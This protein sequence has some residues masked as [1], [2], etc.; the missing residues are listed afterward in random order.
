[1]S[2]T[3]PRSGRKRA[4]TPAKRQRLLDAL[5]GG[6]SLTQ[7]ARFLFVNRSSIHRELG[8]DDELRAAVDAARV[9]GAHNH[10]EAQAMSITQV[11]DPEARVAQLE[12]DRAR[13]A[14][15]ASVGQA[16]A[17]SKL[18]AV[19]AAL[20]EARAA[21][22]R[23]RLVE[24]ERERREQERIEREHQRERTEAQ[25]K[26]AKQTTDLRNAY[27]DIEALAA[28]MVVAIKRAV[29]IGAER[30]M[31]IGLLRHLDGDEGSYG[32]GKTKDAM[33]DRLT[34]LLNREAGLADVRCNAV[35]GFGLKPLPELEK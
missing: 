16:G 29:E 24:E 31:A 10:K 7:S 32:S 2:E 15:D 6:M 23:A 17:D 13:A 25:K 35:Y 28:P 30:D 1:M 21:V 12:R 19:E 4:L 14:Y 26:I 34:Y 33:T 22:E 9:E 3:R 20:A 18:R 11:D 27:A 8:R 5:M